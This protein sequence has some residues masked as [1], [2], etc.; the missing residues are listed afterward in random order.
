MLRLLCGKICPFG[1]L[2]DW[3][4]KIPFPKKVR[5]FK[6]DKVLRY[7]KFAVLIAWP[8]AEELSLFGEWQMSAPLVIGLTALALLCILT[9]RPF[10][11]YLCPVGAV[12]GLFNLLPPGRYKVNSDS[13]TKCGAC[14]R[15][16]KMDIEPYKTP[17]SIECVR[18]GKCKKKCPISAIS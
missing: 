12:L 15:V 6:G 5:T 2:Q 17:N 10:C 18:C 4:N 3:M 9:S 1:Y 14:S 16:C 8:V 13:C 7:L 11:K